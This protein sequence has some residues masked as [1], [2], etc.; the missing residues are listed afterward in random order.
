[1]KNIIT[2]DLVVSLAFGDGDY[3][4]PKVVAEADIASAQHTYIRP[5]LGEELYKK[6]VEAEYSDL[7]SEQI[8]PA[9]AMA[10]RVMLQP[11]LNV[12]CGQAGLVAPSTPVSEAASTSAAQ[13][14]QRS[15]E[16]RRNALLARLSDHLSTNSTLYPE[17][18]AEE[19]ALKRCSI[20][21]GII[22]IH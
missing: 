20:Y 5:I 14:L 12:R 3:I 4:D 15:L 7:I 19:D 2:P 22:Q 8:A 1:M 9:L 10:V 16:R 21:G 13:T 11:S 18:K 17:Y 6:V